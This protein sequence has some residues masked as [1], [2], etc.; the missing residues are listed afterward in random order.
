[1]KKTLQFSIILAILAFSASLFAQKKIKEGVVK[2]EMKADGD[3]PSMALLGGST[4]DFYFS[5][6][7]QRM[8]MSMMGGMM[9]VQTFIPTKSPKDG[10]IL[11]D[12]MGQKIQIIDLTEDD[13]SNS[14][15]F[16]KTDNIKEI[17]YDPSDK[18]D[19]AGYPCYRARLKLN[20]GMEMKYYITEKILPPTPIKSDSKN[21]LKGYPLEMIIDTGAGVEM[22]LT[23]KEVS[24]NLEK[25]TFKV[26]DGYAKMT[27]EEFEKQMGGSLNLG[28]GSG[29]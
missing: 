25:D 1:M 17:V 24:G 20:D 7:N 13:L 22:T 28:G 15:S 8:D 16:M 12:M 23:A 29:N 26:P 11:M 10:A 14:N 9:R 27:M 6:D 5:G 2:F 18:K 4:L 19:I 21:I 3:D